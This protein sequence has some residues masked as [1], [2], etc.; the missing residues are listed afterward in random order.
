MWFCLPRC[1]GSS[2]ILTQ[3]NPVW[4]EG[5]DKERTK[6][7]QR[8]SHPKHQRCDPGLITYTQQLITHI[9]LIISQSHHYNYWVFIPP[10]KKEIH[11]HKCHYTL[12][13]SE[14]LHCLNKLYLEGFQEGVEV[15]EDDLR[16]LIFPWVDKKQ[17]IG[18]S[19]EGEKDERGLH[20]FPA[21]EETTDQTTMTDRLSSLCVKG[22]FWILLP[23]W[24]L[25]VNRD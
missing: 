21:G 2:K 14:R 8:G 23:D 3:R 7:E 5:R 6:H 15:D 25:S 18:D 24:G 16:D 22:S 19:Q 11:P 10:Q 20:G 12:I 17:H 4:E 1:L 13:V 9:H